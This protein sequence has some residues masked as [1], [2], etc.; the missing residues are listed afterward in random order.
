LA[1]FENDNDNWSSLNNDVAEFIYRLLWMT[2]ERN[3]NL[4]YLRGIN[5]FK[6]Y[7]HI[8]KMND[9]VEQGLVAYNGAA[10]IRISAG[11]VYRISNIWR[12]VWNTPSV[13][14]PCVDDVIEMKFELLEMELSYQES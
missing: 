11:N 4:Y 9:L 10:Y 13:D 8:R 5:S 7:V 2:W 12:R 14:M 1:I 6:D 3:Q